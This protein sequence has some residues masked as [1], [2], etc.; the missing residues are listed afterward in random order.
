MGFDFRVEYKAGKSNIAADSLSRRE[1][2]SEV[3]FVFSNLS[4]TT[5]FV[6]AAPTRCSR[7]KAIHKN[8]TMK[9][10]ATKEL[11]TDVGANQV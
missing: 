1:D 5:N 8:E 7:L 3:K 4:S 9:M 10:I 2:D 11:R 6:Q